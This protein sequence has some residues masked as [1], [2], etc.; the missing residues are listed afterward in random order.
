L[1]THP[2]DLILLDRAKG[3]FAAAA[4]YTNALGLTDQQLQRE[5]DNLQLLQDK[6]VLCLQVGQFSNAIP[7]F[8]R[9][10]SGTNSYASRMYRAGAYLQTGQWEAATSDYKEALRLFPGFT[11]PYYRLADVYSRRGDTNAANR[12]YQQGLSNG[13]RVADE[14]LQREPDNLQ[15]LQE[16][17]RL[18]VQAGQF[19]NAIPAFTRMLSLTNSYRVRMYRAQAY[20]QT[21]QWEA[22]AADYREALRAFPTSYEPHYGLADLAFRRGDT[23][24]ANRYY[25]QGNT[26]AIRLA[27]QQLQLTP[28]NLQILVEKGVLCARM[29]QFSNAIPVFTR[30][31]SL[32][33]NYSGRLYRAMAYLETSQWDAAEADYKELLRLFPTTFQPYLGLGEVALRRGQTN[34]AIQHYQQ[35]LSKAPTNQAEFR[36]VAARLKSLQPK[37]P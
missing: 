35:Y 21:G 8:T 13:L 7:V 28:D 34:A 31:L 17:A 19:S 14:Q 33:N 25:Q 5:P 22:A 29:G 32:T 15:A 18:S 37:V 4:S 6:G 24:A 1:D 30:V 16:K 2:G 10:L 26:Q 9:V 3:L 23:N 27:D 12:Y 36:T 20:S 11:E